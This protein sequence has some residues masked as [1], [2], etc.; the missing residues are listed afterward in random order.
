M[1]TFRVVNKGLNSILVLLPQDR[2]E[3]QH[4]MTPQTVSIT[5]PRSVQP[6]ICYL[7]KEHAMF[8]NILR[9]L[10][11]GTILQIAAHILKPIPVI[12][13]MARLVALTA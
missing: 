6:L 13:A 11:I 7:S 4:W 10:V 1:T 2:G 8:R 5:T 9:K 3:K 12:G